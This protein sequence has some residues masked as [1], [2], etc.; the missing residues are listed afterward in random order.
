MHEGGKVVSQ[1]GGV[2]VDKG[3]PSVPVKHAKKILSGDYVEMDGASAIS[4]HPRGRPSRTQALLFETS[5]EHIYLAAVLQSMC[6]HSQ[7]A[8]AGGNP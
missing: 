5:I 4:E 3:L 2:Y 6:Q 7:D 8:I 1:S